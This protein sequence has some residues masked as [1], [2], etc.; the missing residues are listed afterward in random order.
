MR[1]LLVLPAALI[2]GAAADP[3][4][5]NFP[6][7]PLLP[8][9]A[10]AQQLQAFNHQLDL[11]GCVAEHTPAALR[12]GSLPRIRAQV[13]AA[14]VGEAVASRAMTEAQAAALSDRLVDQD[15][16]QLTQCQ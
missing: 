5:L 7:A 15:V 6:S 14:C 8:P 11:A 3:C 2:V 16:A 13:R 10:T 1:A 9:G 12:A 4:A